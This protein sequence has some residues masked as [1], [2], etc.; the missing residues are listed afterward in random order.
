MHDENKQD[1]SEF[2]AQ[3]LIATKSINSIKSINP[4]VFVSEQNLIDIIDEV[5]DE[6][7]DDM[8][9]TKNF[10]FNGMVKIG[11]I[12]YLMLSSKYSKV[13]TS[14]ALI[15]YNV[16]VAEDAAAVGGKQRARK[17]KVKRKT[18][19][20]RKTKRTSNAKGISKSKGKKGRKTKKGGRKT[21][22]KRSN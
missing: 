8:K 10:C 6:V 9:K 13:K 12:K 14:I 3:I 15:P 22:R 5:N 17:Y 4:I 1:K 7:N 21:R 16:A 11:E 18:K 2:I 19:R 20:N